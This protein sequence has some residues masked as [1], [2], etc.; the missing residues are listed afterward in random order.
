MPSFAL[1]PLRAGHW[2]GEPRQPRGGRPAVQVR[3]GHL[4]V[5]WEFFKITKHLF[6]SLH[7]LF[8]G[9]E[10]FWAGI[11]FSSACRDFFDI[12]DIF[13][14]IFLHKRKFDTFSMYFLSWA[15]RGTKHTSKMLRIYASVEIIAKKKS[16][17]S[18]KSR[19]AREVKKIPSKNFPTGQIRN[20]MT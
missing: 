16:K 14:Q 7:F 15:K 1:L 18:K 11:F 2:A 20:A 17:L 19:Q 10:N 13:R 3:A 8:G 5:F 9:Q 6:M 4:D 12:W